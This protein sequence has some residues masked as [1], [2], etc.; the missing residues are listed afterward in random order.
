MNRQTLLWAVVVFFG[1]SLI[2]GGLN[3]ATEDSSTGVRLGVQLAAL[4]VIVGA[5]VLVVRMRD[6]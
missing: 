2:F 3:N 4:A 6:R 5:V 1:A